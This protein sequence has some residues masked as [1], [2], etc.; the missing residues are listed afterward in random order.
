MIQ[1]QQRSGDAL[2]HVGVDCFFLSH[3]FLFLFSFF[4]LLSDSPQTVKHL[5]TPSS[6]VPIHLRSLVSL[7]RAANFGENYTATQPSSLFERLCDIFG[8]TPLSPWGKKPLSSFWNSVRGVRG[9]FFGGGR[10]D[11][12]MKTTKLRQLCFHNGLYRVTGARLLAVPCSPYWRVFV[13]GQVLL[14]PAGALS[15]IWICA[16]FVDVHG[17]GMALAYSSCCYSHSAW[18]RIIFQRCCWWGGIYLMPHH[19]CHTRAEKHTENGW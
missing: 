5:V 2:E 14:T 10:R 7:N 1:C 4:V 17:F 16:A 11:E 9:F 3:H 18:E 19:D 12:T 13:C 6:G 8:L 15:W